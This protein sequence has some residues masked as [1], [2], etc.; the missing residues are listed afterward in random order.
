[1]GPRRSRGA[2]AVTL[3]FQ[4]EHIEKIRAEEK[5]TTRRDWSPNYAGVTVGNVYIA[6]PRMFITDED[7]DCYVRITDTYPEPLGEMTNRDADREGGYTLSEFRN[8]WR[9]LNGEWDPE[10]TVTVVDFDYVGRS[11]PG[12]A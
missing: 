6:S 1:M 8:L 4:P 7:A 12:V 11:R 9:D 5:T 3:L 2:E 10:Q